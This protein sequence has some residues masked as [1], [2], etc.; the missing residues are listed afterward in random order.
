MMMVTRPMVG[1]LI[2]L[3]GLFA[4]SEAGEEPGPTPGAIEVTPEIRQALDRIS[5][6]SLKGHL[7]FIA[8]DALEGR[9]TPSK[10]LD[11]AAEYIAAQF[12]RAG[13]QPAGT[14]GYFQVANWFVS[15]PD[16][17][18]F[19][20][21]LTIGETSF[22]VPASLVTASITSAIDIKNAALVRV[23][24]GDLESLGKLAPETVAGKVVLTELIDP[25]TVQGNQRF[26]A[27]SLYRRTLDLLSKHKPLL[28]VMVDGNAKSAGG[29][30][31]IRLIDPEQQQRRG[32][33][34]PLTFASATP[35]VRVHDP[36]VLVAF[37]TKAAGAV[38]GELNLAAGA[39]KE[40][41]VQLKNV[42][43]LLKGSD[44]ELSQTCVI[45]SAHY[46]HIGVQPGA[47]PDPIF[48]GANDD[49]SGTVSV[50]E[51]AGALAG[52]NPRP[53]RSILFLTFFG[54]EKGLLGSRYYGK[55]PLIPLEK[56]AAMVNLEQVGRTDSTEGPQIKAA[57]MTGFDFSEVGPILAAAGER[58]GV[59]IFKHPR[60]SD[61][62]FGR[63]D[64]QALA[65]LGVPAHTICVAYVY[66][67]YH[68][69]FD[70]WDKIDY[71]N[72][73]RVN[74]AFALGL[75]S[76]ADNP[77]LPQW[78]KENPKA[79]RYRKAMEERLQKK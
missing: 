14:D 55:H 42:A 67:D 75:L 23:D 28:I 16:P 8:S 33:A 47:S 72:M 25:R 62:F 44:P 45:V 1:M 9:D 29:L 32:A 12:R 56:T 60:N 7:S 50:I 31:P 40:H 71:A 66:D 59:T 53:K 18:E 41:P 26:G 19:R 68:G 73:A 76:I 3:C 2:V 4:R 6:D 54:E 69:L 79:E 78:N 58:V 65:D 48:N 13:L 30:G 57:S 35:S 38:P 37:Q 63:S 51:L 74:Q 11:L 52:L 20:L 27:F 22:T 10:G 39:P 36:A 43:G 49:G 5:A 70:H 15:Q 17:A 46:D 34:A 21:T 64:N 24:S 77:K 61:A